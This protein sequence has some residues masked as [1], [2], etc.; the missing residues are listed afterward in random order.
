MQNIDLQNIFV[1]Y[2]H[3]FDSVHRNKRIEC[4]KKFDVPDKL[5]RLKALTLIE[6]RVKRKYYYYYYYTTISTTTTTTT[7]TISVLQLLD[8]GFEYCRCNV[9]IDLIAF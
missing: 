9:C 4:L 6:T 2:T 7:T 8:D 5:N 3:A 1:N